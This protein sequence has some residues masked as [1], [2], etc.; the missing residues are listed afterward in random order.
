MS[1]G[2]ITKPS[3]IKIPANLLEQPLTEMVFSLMKVCEVEVDDSKLLEQ[4]EDLKKG[5][6]LDLR[7]RL[8]NA[9]PKNL[10]ISHQQLPTL[11]NMLTAG[12]QIYL[13]GPS[14]AGK[15]YAAAQCAKGLN[16][17]FYFTGAIASEFKL[18]GFI[19]AQGRIVSTDFRKAYEKGGL[20]LFDEIDAS[21]PQAILAFNAALSNDFMDFPDK[22]V[23]RHEKFYCIA[24]ANTYGQGADRQYIG[25]NQLDAASLD[26]FVCLNWAYDELL[27]RDLASNN[28]W[29]DHV[30][31][32]RKWV[33]TN[34]IRHVISP[35]ASIN[36]G[37]LLATGMTWEE[38][39]EA[40]IW[41]GMDSTTRNKISQHT[42]R[43]A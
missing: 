31:K 23:N 12:M 19:D 35:R 26:R 30:Q 24:A 8:G 27:E 2:I 14:G 7:L 25:R 21:F 34:K 1:K 5:K 16:I 43:S 4:I 11:L 29:T 39:E 32:I 20:F 9:K 10:G 36:G 28:A 38:V 15:T 17:P 40:V 6:P 3:Q 42:Q 33:E 37:K 13:V 41:K 22:R 18:T